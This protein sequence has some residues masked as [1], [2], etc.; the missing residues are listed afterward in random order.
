MRF[1][2]LSI[3]P[4]LVA[5]FSA[6]GDRPS[7][8]HIRYVAPAPQGAGDGSSEENAGGDLARAIGRALADP[9]ID[10]LVLLPGRYALTDTITLKP[11]PKPLML[12]ASTTGAAV[13]DGQNTVA[14][15][16]LVN[17][18]DL[19]IKGLVFR[20]FRQNG[21]VMIGSERILIDQNRFD[22]I[23]S[24]AW[25][26]AAIHGVHY[27]SDIRVTNNDVSDTGYAGILFEASK[28]GR[29]SNIRIEGNRLTRTCLAVNDCGA[30]YA[31]GRAR[32]SAG[33]LISGNVIHDFGPPHAQAQAIY[34]DDGLSDATVT[35][36]VITGTGQF[37]FHLHGGARNRLTGNDVN[38]CSAEGYLFY[39]ELTQ[40]MVG[41]VVRDN[42]IRLSLAHRSAS[43]KLL[44]NK[45]SP[46]DLRSN[47][48]VDCQ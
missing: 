22:N 42:K 45:S 30:I 18:T 19:T 12:R 32:D 25:S 3:A 8:G 17:G 33:F 34:L 36:N 7:P 29:L 38:A 1:A 2:A 37:A 46:V 26:Q 13:L 11:G 41:N 43:A 14:S 9:Q 31:Q 47:M 24:T 48:F 16:L 40:S 27:L 21:I 15:A 20:G 10:E 5:C 44:I 6:S 4:L 35:R 23:A 39:Q 28:D